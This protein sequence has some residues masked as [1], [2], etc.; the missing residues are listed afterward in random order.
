MTMQIESSVPARTSQTWRP[1]HAYLMAVVCL[2]IGCAIGYLIRGSAPP[3]SS[4][5]AAAAPSGA[6]GPVP[7][8]AANGAA[9]PAQMPSL[10]DMKRMAEKQAQPLLT[11]LE[12]KPNDAALLNKTALTY[13]AA[14]Q[15]EK[16]AEY[17]KKSLESDPKNVA[18]RDDYASCLYF[19]GDVDGALTQLNKSL[20]FD[21]KHAGTLFN[22]GMIEWRGRNDVDAAVS[23]WEKLLRL[24][25]GLPQKDKENVQ[26]LIEVAKQSKAPVAEKQ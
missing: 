10:D 11:E 14:H 18:V 1:L 17:F 25:P 7:A 4:N 8:S 19:L 13:K 22:I 12:K 21:P 2:V 15:F 3:K 26:H 5:I 24:N 20:T 16:A 23:S 9:A 6:G